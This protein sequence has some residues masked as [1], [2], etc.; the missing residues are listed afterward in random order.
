MK[1][2]Q[3]Y[4][5][6]WIVFILLLAVNF[7]LA[8]EIPVQHAKLVEIY[9]DLDL[10][11]AGKI[12]HVD[13]IMYVLESGNHRIVSIKD[14]EIMKQIGRIGQKKGEFYYPQ[15]F[16]IDKKGR[17]IVL[18]F[19]EKGANRVQIVDREGKYIN[20]FLTGTKPWGFGAD[21]KGNIYLGQPHFGNLIT[22]YSP[23][24]KKI[25]RLGKL[26]LPSEIYGKEYEKKNSIY[27]IPM[28]R[29]N[30][31]IDE[32]DNIYV[33]FLFM[34]LLIKFNPK[35]EV[36]FKKVLDRPGLNP[37]M[38]AIW[39]P[40]SKDAKQFFSRNIDGPQMAV[41]T[42]DMLYNHG[43]KRIYILLG[44]NE[45]LVLDLTGQEQAVIKPG[46]VKGALDRMFIN[47]QD[48]IIVRFFFHPEFYKLVIKNSSN[49]IQEKSK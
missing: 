30:M 31:V 37:V 17:Y 9:A 12:I 33:S 15:N 14:N 38:R 19:S 48:E 25:N 46:I 8:N 23:K 35:G 32:D 7:S 13:G 47:E 10:S 26:I 29:V 39:D 4:N 21:S 27:K 44:S 36:I 2:Y 24:G 20:G 34:P 18:D 11:L 43:Q 49:K 16:L 3:I 41:V 28:N 1:C 22:V 42:K 6:R 5:K 40:G 45:I